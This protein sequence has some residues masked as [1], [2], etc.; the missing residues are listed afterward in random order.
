MTSV[1]PVVIA[2]TGNPLISGVPTASALASV[3]LLAGTP[4]ISST[5]SGTVIARINGGCTIGPNRLR[6]CTAQIA[7]TAPTT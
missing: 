7:T 4:V 2:I 3:S 1:R 5:T 6:R